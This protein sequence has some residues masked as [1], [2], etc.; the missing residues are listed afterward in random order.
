MEAIA[1]AL[2]TTLA[3]LIGAAFCYV[4]HHILVLRIDALCLDMDMGMALM[5]EYL[6]RN[7]GLPNQ[8]AVESAEA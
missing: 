1:G 2:G 4:A 8:S 5:L 3:G 7:D 6:A